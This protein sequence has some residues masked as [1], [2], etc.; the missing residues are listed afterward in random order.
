MTAGV[1]TTT[2][3]L[4]LPVADN[5]CATVKAAATA[6]YAGLG[7]TGISAQTCSTNPVV[8]STTISFGGNSSWTVTSITATSPTT[9]TATDFDPA[10]ASQFWLMAFSS[11]IILYFGSKGI[12]AVLNFVK[13]A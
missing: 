2:F 7:Y 3:G 6:H 12:G 11:V 5:T 13:H 10:V 9:T 1:L 8:A 4:T